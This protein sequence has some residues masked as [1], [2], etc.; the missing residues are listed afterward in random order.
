MADWREKIKTISNTKGASAPEPAKRLG[1]G[2]LAI[3]I[4]AVSILAFIIAIGLFKSGSW[5]TAS[6]AGLFFLLCAAMAVLLLLPHKTN[7]L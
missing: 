5:V 1:I 7:T 3:A 4:L 2:C 6:F